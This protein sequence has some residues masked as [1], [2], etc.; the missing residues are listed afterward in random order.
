MKGHL[1]CWSDWGKSNGLKCKAEDKGPRRFNWSRHIPDLKDSITDPSTVRCYFTVQLQQLYSDPACAFQTVDEHR[2]EI[3]S[4]Q[5][6]M[7]GSHAQPDVMFMAWVLDKLKTVDFFDKIF[8]RD[9]QVKV[10]WDRPKPLDLPDKPL[11]DDEPE[12]AFPCSPRSAS[13]GFGLRHRLERP[14][15]N[16]CSEAP[17]RSVKKAI[18]DAT[19]IA[20]PC[21]DAETEVCTN[22]SETGVGAVVGRSW[23][24]DLDAR[25]RCRKELLAMSRAACFRVSAGCFGHRPQTARSE[26]RQTTL[27]PFKDVTC[28]AYPV[29]VDGVQYLAGEHNILV[30]ALS[31]VQP[32][33]PLEDDEPTQL[34]LRPTVSSASWWNKLTLPSWRKVRSSLPCQNDSD[35]VA[36]WNDRSG[37]TAA[38]RLFAPSRRP[39]PTPR[40]LLTHGRTR[41]RKYVQML[42]KSVLERLLDVVGC[43]S[44]T[45]ERGDGRS[46]GHVQSSS[47]LY[48]RFRVSAG[49]FAHRPQTAGRSGRKGAPSNTS[50][51]TVDGVQYLAGEHKI[52]VDA[53][54]RVQP[55]KPLEDDEPTKLSAW[56]TVLSASWWNKLTLPSWRK[57]RLPT[58]LCVLGSNNSAPPRIPLINLSR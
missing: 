52:L 32:V 51:V 12:Q 34:S 53:L 58:T 27:R 11:E 19:L 41:R 43:W 31:R 40:C 48:A 10:S 20:H 25:T 28:Y 24:L 57:V 37:T 29:T 18:A 21:P 35:F 47:S 2:T 3:T 7:K 15:R 8:R 4:G 42:A 54:S 9:S 6:L 36:A 44:W 30:D 26:R 55:V 33:K 16:D 45:P 46:C 13:K 49:R 1:M 5:G 50:P 39:S 22:A 56:P 38:K 23:M 17:F 14:Q